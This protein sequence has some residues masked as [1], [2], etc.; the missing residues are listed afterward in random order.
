MT[1]FWKIVIII[2]A[3]HFV[4]FWHKFN[5]SL[6]DE[7]LPII[8]KYFKKVIFYILNWRFMICFGLAWMITNGWSYLFVLFGNIFH[9][10]WMR[11]IGLGYLAFLWFP[12]TPEKLITVPIAMFLRKA[13]FPKHNNID[14]QIRSKK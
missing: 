10:N 5:I 7:W 13:L 1:S 8:K 12:G 9:L 3:I 14:E 2:V 4:I 11:N 6:R